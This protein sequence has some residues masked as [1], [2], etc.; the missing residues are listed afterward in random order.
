M[1]FLH[2]TALNLI[3]GAGTAEELE[4]LSRTIRK[5][6]KDEVMELARDYKERADQKL[7]EIDEHLT[8]EQQPFANAKNYPGETSTDDY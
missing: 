3:H 2:G 6:S 5:W 4:Q 1:P 7:K 8:C